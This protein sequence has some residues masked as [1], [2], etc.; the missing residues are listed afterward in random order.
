MKSAMATHFLSIA[1]LPY[2]TLGCIFRRAF[3]TRGSS[4]VQGPYALVERQTHASN[5]NP[6][7]WFKHSRL[8]GRNVERRYTMNK[9][10]LA[11]A[12]AHKTG[13]AQGKASEVLTALFGAEEGQG[14]IAEALSKD[15]KVAIPGF[16]TFGTRKRAARTGIN[17]ATQ[18]KIEIAAKTAVFFKVGKTL[19]ERFE[20]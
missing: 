6:A 3:C 13:I 16:G 10:E 17:P 4:H 19:K 18:K 9:K 7:R 12:L 1:S 5:L 8:A 20:K 11:V 2:P 15:D 14:I